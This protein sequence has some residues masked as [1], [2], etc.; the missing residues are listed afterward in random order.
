[1]AVETL[2]TKTIGGKKGVYYHDDVWNLKYLKGFK[3]RHLTEQIAN[4]NAERSA[5]LRAEGAR[6]RREVREFLVNV[7]KAKML[8]GMEK[9][10]KRKKG[11]ESGNIVSL[12]DDDASEKVPG[13]KKERRDFRQTEVMFKAKNDT[14][15][16]QLPGEVQRVLNKIF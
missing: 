10:R 3:W 5:R 16:A 14:V 2:N 9:K 13:R 4:E 1:V 8:D 6:E 15:H 12:D 11:D 7:E